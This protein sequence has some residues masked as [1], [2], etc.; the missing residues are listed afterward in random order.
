ML[1][2]EGI[3]VSEFNPSKVG[4]AKALDNWCGAYF[5]FKLCHPWG[6]GR[7]LAGRPAGRGSV[8][9]SRLRGGG[10]APF[11]QSSERRRGVNGEK[12]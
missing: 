6:P 9:V 4:N 2:R 7:G 11:G 1:T 12:S 3:A 5:P 10:T 8:A